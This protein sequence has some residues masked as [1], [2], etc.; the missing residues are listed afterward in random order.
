MG[1]LQERREGLGGLCETLLLLSLEADKS[2][3]DA[4]AGWSVT[5]SIGIGFLPMSCH[6]LNKLSGFGSSVPNLQAPCLENTAEPS[7]TLN[8]NFHLTHHWVHNTETI[9]T[10]RRKHTKR[11]FRTAQNSADLRNGEIHVGRQFRCIA[12]VCCT[13]PLPRIIRKQYVY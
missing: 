9:K 8:L 7:K 6:S 13:I 2:V 5:D 4:P 1:G 11:L 12:S 3:T 10:K